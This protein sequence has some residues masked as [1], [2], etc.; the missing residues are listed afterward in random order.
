MDFIK[1]VKFNDQGLV[2]AIAQDAESGQILM[3]AWMN[4]ESLRKTVEDGAACYYSRSRQKLWLKGESSGNVQKVEEIRLDCDGDVI[5]MKIHQKGG[6]CHVGYRSCFYRKLENGEWI[7]DG[8][9]MFDPSEVYGKQ[10]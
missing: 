2:P 10:S 7:I 4:E 1:E 3:M 8:E 5:L 6:A 9:K